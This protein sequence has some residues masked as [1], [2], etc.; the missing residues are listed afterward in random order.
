MKVLM[1]NGSPNKNGCTG[2]AL[3]IVADE[4]AANGVDSE[5]IWLGKGPIRGCAACGGC[6]DCRCVFDGDPVNEAAEKLSGADALI[7]GSPVY[8][9]SATGTVTAFLDRLFQ[10]AGSRLVNKPGAAVVS[11]RRG[12][13]SATFDQLNKYFTITCMPLVTSNYWNM[14]HGSKA[15]DVYGDP[16][17]VQTMKVLARNMAWLLK[18][19][20][21]G[22][23][24][25]VEPPAE[26]EKIYFNYVR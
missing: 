14:V 19:I 1:I 11:C 13:A 23:K 12:G 20:E 9:A 15:E 7:V 16:E 2:A 6:R 4:L 25:G 18:C 3:S 8:Y 26:E 22:R 10:V 24:A 5:I 17:G 21:A